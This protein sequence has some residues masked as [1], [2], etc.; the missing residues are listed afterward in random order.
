MRCNELSYNV[1]LPNKKLSDNANSL[2]VGLNL[3]EIQDG[4]IGPS[5]WCSLNHYTLLSSYGMP[6]LP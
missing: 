3:K 4:W 6:T 5:P 2:G 1:Y